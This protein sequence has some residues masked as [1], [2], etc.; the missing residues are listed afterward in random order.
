[1]LGTAAAKRIEP[2]MAYYP[3]V[4]NLTDCKCLVVGG[5]EV[6]LRKAQ[7]LAEAGARVTVIAPDVLG[8]IESLDGVQ[9]EKRSWQPGDAS[10]YTLVIAATDDPVL[11]AEVSAEARAKNILVNVVDDPE[12]CSFIVPACVRRGDLLI[13]V[14]TCGKSPALSKRIR[15]D[16][17][18][19][20]GPEYAEFVDLLGEL[21]GQVKMRYAEQRDR[22]PAFDRLVNCGILELLRA[23]ERDK[24]RKKALE[25]I[26]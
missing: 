10:G 5:G 19:S 15:M 17:E 16:I 25:C 24:A 1:M 14:T 12:L 11:N 21:R 22:E 13:A 8:D 23:G 3:I 18:N 26:W 4:M 6:A 7:S 20:Y 2:E 9:V